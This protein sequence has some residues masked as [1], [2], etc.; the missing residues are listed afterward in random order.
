LPEGAPAHLGLL[1][2]LEMLAAAG[3]QERTQR[4][5]A[6]LLS[7]AGFR[8]QRVVPTPSPMSIVEARPV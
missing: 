3:G 7:R 8:L 5:Y 6:E 1:V 4:E 2:D